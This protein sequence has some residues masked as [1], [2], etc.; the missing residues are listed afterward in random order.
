MVLVHQ[1][2]ALFIKN[3]TLYWRQKI[4]LIFICLFPV[5]L[6]AFVAVLQVAVD[7]LN[8]ND[9]EQELIH[10]P[11]EPLNIF[12]GL[13]ETELNNDYFFNY[14]Y[15]L[16]SSPELCSQKSFCIGELTSNGTG[17]GLL[18]TLVPLQ[19]NWTFPNGTRVTVPYFFVQNST[20][21]VERDLLDI[22]SILNEHIEQ[23]KTNSTLKYL[24][25]DGGM[26]FT[27]A[28]VASS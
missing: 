2:R 27:L 22:Q 24:L 17:A 16:P 28:T 15:A 4:A 1:L 7:N 21:Q 20:E 19:Y 18:S 10:P 9:G 26:Y 25:P 11:P 8:I 6:I 14:F 13:N 5:V 12:Q 3:L 23:Y